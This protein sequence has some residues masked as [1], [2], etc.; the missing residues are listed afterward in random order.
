L[1]NPCIS[2]GG[3]ADKEAIVMM[4]GRALQGQAARP[5]ATLPA[6]VADYLESANATPD[7]L[8]L[9][10]NLRTGAFNDQ[11]SVVRP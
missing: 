7:D 3:A 9:E 10:R 5:P 2:L 6:A 8:A 11:P 1:A 4:T